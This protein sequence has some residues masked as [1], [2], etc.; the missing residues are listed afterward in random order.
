MRKAIIKVSLG[1]ANYTSE[2]DI[3]KYTKEYEIADEAWITA[4][5][6]AELQVRSKYGYML[7]MYEFSDIL[8]DLEYE[9]E[10]KED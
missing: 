10:I 7:P 4:L 3:D 8:K 5:R 6:F 1:K 2:F 9:Y